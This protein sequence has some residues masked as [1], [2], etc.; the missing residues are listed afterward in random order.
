MSLQPGDIVIIRRENKYTKWFNP[1]ILRVNSR[2][3]SFPNTYWLKDL[4]GNEIHDFPFWSG[5]LK[6]VRI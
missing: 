5:Y 2:D 1:G 4:Y 6:K 3:D